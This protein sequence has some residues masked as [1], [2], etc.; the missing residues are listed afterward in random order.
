VEAGSGV[1]RKRREAQRARRMNGNLQLQGFREG[2]G[3]WENLEEVPETWDRGD[4]Q[5][6]IQ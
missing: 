3:V 1:G 5:G 4:S 6:S 2:Q